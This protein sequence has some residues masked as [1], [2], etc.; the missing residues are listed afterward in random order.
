M[1]A[2]PGVVAYTEQLL[3]YYHDPSAAPHDH[4]PAPPTPD[5]VI[6]VSAAVAQLAALVLE[7]QKTGQ[8]PDQE[9]SPE[10]KLAVAEM[11]SARWKDA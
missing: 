6:E 8:T 9:P 5:V 7:Y 1:T 4:P 3:A 10:T 11:I 2:G